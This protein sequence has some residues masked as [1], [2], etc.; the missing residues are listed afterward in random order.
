MK[1]ILLP[2]LSLCLLAGCSSRPNQANIELRK[3]RQQMRGRIAELERG[4][5]QLRSQI[6]AIEA[7]RPTTRNVTQDVLEQLYTAGGVRLGRLTGSNDAGDGLRV[8]VIPQDGTGDDMKAVGTVTVEAYDLA[9]SEVRLAR[10]NFEPAAVRSSWLSGFIT[11]G[12][13]LNC[14]WP[15]GS[16]PADGADLMIRVTFT[17]LLT[18]REF[19]ATKE[20]N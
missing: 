7:D 10:W 13:A 5:Q 20:L 4:N 12:F 18:G 15:E 16:K 1:P 11:S 14:P 17:D 3:E 8:F 9:A 19:K 2:I 6:R